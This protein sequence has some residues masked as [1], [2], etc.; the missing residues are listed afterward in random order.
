EVAERALYEAHVDRVFRLAYRLAGHDADLAQDFAQETFVRAFGKLREFQGRS[1]FSTWLHSIT[2]SVS[3]NGLRKVKRIRERE[4]ELDDVT[5][6]S[7]FSA[8]RHAEPD[9]KERLQQA[10]AGLPEH[11]RAVFVMYDMEGY[12]HEEIGGALN[13]PVGTSKAR[14]SRAREKLREQLADFAGE[15]VQ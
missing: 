13:V 3:L 14:L 1:A 7:G 6:T 12:T 8:T 4:V 9:L 2:V 10:I 15:W 5:T 11:Y